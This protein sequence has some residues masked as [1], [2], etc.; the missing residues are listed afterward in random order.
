MIYRINRNVCGQLFL[1]GVTVDKF[2]SHFTT[3]Y[4]TFLLGVTGFLY[5]PVSSE[6]PLRC[7]AQSQACS[8]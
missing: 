6:P 2:A 5:P 8:Q 4:A 1:P 7:Y 3:L